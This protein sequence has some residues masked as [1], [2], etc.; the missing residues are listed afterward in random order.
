ML[1]LVLKLLHVLAVAMFLGN[2]T[3]GLFWKVH[4]ERSGDPRLIAHAFDGIMS[5][6]RWFTIPG[7]IVIVATGV[8]NAALGGFPLLRT[9][10]IAW[11]LVLFTVSGLAFM[12]RVVPL[13]RAIAE[14]AHAATSAGAFDR[15]RYRVL[16]RAWEFW[17][18]IALAA[19]LLAAVLMVL[20]PVLPAL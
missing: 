5:S 7:V 14:L 6:D 12:F 19:P 4:A 8:A 17:G 1:Y 9:G 16:S 11:S 20:K 15:E 2:I 10:W 3:T 18:G 13:Q